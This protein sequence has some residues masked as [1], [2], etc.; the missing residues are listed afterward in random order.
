MKRLLTKTALLITLPVITAGAAVSYYVYSENK[1]PAF[2]LDCHHF[3]NGVMVGAPPEYRRHPSI[4]DGL[5]VVDAKRFSVE[6]PSFDPK[7]HPTKEEREANPSVPRLE[8]LLFS[9]RK[10]IPGFMEKYLGPNPKGNLP[11][12]NVPDG[13]IYGL[14]RWQLPASNDFR[15]RE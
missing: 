13:E 15:N 10:T 2:G 7:N 12:F 11:G 1:E 6:Y 14:E 5:N 3:S 4:K 8:L 9:V